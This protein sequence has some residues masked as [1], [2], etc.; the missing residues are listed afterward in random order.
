MKV[1]CVHCGKIFSY[2]P[3]WPLR[4]PRIHCTMRCNMEFNRKRKKESDRSQ[5]ERWKERQAEMMENA[6]L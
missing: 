3:T 6:G 5:L 1:H 4:R 2:K